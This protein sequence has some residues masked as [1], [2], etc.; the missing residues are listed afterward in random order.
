MAFVYTDESRGLASEDLIQRPDK[1]KASSR[2]RGC[3]SI[4][5]NL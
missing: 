4:A 2:G 1:I 3:E 5:I